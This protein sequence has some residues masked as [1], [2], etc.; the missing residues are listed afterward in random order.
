MTM[1][2]PT[3]TI[4]FRLPAS[5]AKLLEEHGAARQMSRGDIARQLVIEGLTD[6]GVKELKSDIAELLEVNQKLLRNQNRAT[7]ALLMKAGKTDKQEAIAFVDT[8]MQH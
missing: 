7:Q 8:H 5:L 1:K 3:V 2:E 6:S 4:S